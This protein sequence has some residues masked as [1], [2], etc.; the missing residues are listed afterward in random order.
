MVKIYLV[1]HCEAIG[2]Q[3]RLFQGSIDLDISETGAK[4]LPYLQKRFETIHLDRVY[5]SPLI[6][7]VKTAQAIVGKRELPVETLADLTETDG[8]IV[9]GRPFVETFNAI[10]GLADI[11]DNHPEDFAPEGGEPMRHAYERIWRGIMTIAEQNGGKTVAAATHGGVLRCLTCRLLTGDISHLKEMTWTEN[12]A[13]SLLEF[14]DNLKP[15]LC[16]FNDNSHLPEE[17]LP[18]Y[19]RVSSFMARAT[20]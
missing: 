6:R 1:R 19:S 13:V 20:K 5:S 17:L 14:D 4:Q 8:G 7:A 18:S 2:N 12:T 15:T 9:E 3:Q 11:W 16:F 10:P